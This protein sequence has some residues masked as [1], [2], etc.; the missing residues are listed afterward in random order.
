MLQELRDSEHH[1][2]RRAI[3]LEFVVNLALKQIG[4]ECHRRQMTYLQPYVQVVR[5]G[6]R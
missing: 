6:D 4:Q 1:I 3:L 2:R 5:V